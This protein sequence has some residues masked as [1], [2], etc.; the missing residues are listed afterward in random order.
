MKSCADP[1]VGARY[2]ASGAALDLAIQKQVNKKRVSNCKKGLIKHSFSKKLENMLPR[3]VRMKKGMKK[4]MKKAMMAG[5]LLTVG[6]ACNTSEG[7]QITGTLPE[8]ENGTQIEL[9]GIDTNGQDSLLVAGVVTDGNFE[10]PV[11][12]QCI[13]ACLRIPEVLPRIPFFF[14]PGIHSYK[15]EV[16]AEGSM[17]VKG[18]A[19]QEIW[20]AYSARNKAFDQEKKKIE[21][22]YREAAKRDDLFEKMHHRAIYE[23]LKTAQE[24][25]E[26]SL[27]RQNDN[28]VAATLVWLRSR[29]LAA[30]RK[31]GEKVALLGP[32]ALQTPPGQAVKRMAEAMSRT[33][34]GNIAPDFTQNDPDG[35]PVSLY[36]IQAKVKVLDFWASWCGPCRAETPNVRRIYDKYKDKGLEIISVSLDTKRENWL[37]TIE[38]DKMEWIHTSDLKGWDNAVA[39]MYGVRSVPA[40]YVLDAENRIVG[41]NL[42][43]QELE[44]T[45]RMLLNE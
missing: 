7:Y 2:S 44:D 1:D 16:D 17:Q 34:N 3:N 20:N 27:L 5:I 12:G 41:Q 14:E 25:Y 21:T 4:A 43:G 29:E 40:I 36:G 8:I 30:A 9:T 42:R 37:Q 45:I 26:D 32:N 35:N 18:G 39:R 10:I 38:T 22:A 11:T 31:I 13:M 19:L 33:E 15:L 23:D 24:Q 6:T 28:I